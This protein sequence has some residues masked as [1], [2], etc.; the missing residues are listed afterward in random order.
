MNAPKNSDNSFTL[1]S[2]D[3]VLDNMSDSFS[4]IDKDW[5]L[6]YLNKV[7][8]QG[9]ALAKDM[10]LIEKT[11][12]LGTNIWE[13]FPMLVG[14][15]IYDKYHEAMR[16]QVPMKFTTHYEP[17]DSYT[18]VSVYPLGDGGI[19][20][21]SQDVSER[22]RAERQLREQ[23]ERLELAT[24]A[25]RIGLWDFNPRTGELQWDAR[26][27]EMFG[28]KPE[29]SVDYQKFVELLLPEDREP[30]D[31][32]VQRSLDPNGDGLFE[33][34]YRVVH[35]DGSLHYLVARGKS[36][37]T[38][39][40]TE[41]VATRFIGTL[42]DVTARRMQ[43]LEL[44]EQREWLRVT[45]QSIGDAVITTDTQGVTTYLNPV[46]EALTGWK[47]DE[48]Q[49]KPLA[50][51]FN[52]INEVTHEKQENPVERVLAEG[53]TVGLANHTVLISKSGEESPI[54]DSAAPIR[55]AQGEV[56]GV[57]LVFHDATET[58][59]A[60]DLLKRNNRRIGRILEGIGEA[61]YSLDREW[62]II[63]A[64][65]KAQQILAQLKGED[66]GASFD[67]I[68]RNLWAEYPDMIWTELYEKYH[69]AVRDQ[70]PV[71][72]QFTYSTIDGDFTVRAFPSLEGLS[73]FF[74]QV[75]S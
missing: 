65:E 40:G 22:M 23:K 26:C 9:L 33:A 28:L 24:K 71:D 59:K 44:D 61:F 60:E 10:G 5:R 13:E 30:T 47:L 31:A 72:F 35:A 42:T 45:M 73:V 52:I 55:N 74:S 20:V 51:V 29:D 56:L 27:K 36:H 43:D 37:F 58:R 1:P 3:A 2:I 68:G 46:A 53:I 62:N 38:G 11:D 19:A 69:Q 6:T 25:A 70:Q 18:N 48:A 7:A 34:D 41:R 63:F 64:N 4:V 66:A 57:V 54:E 8:A 14:T 17:Y 12:L 39:E 50:E 32:A 75:A 15:D 49:G 67:P 16:A 21:F